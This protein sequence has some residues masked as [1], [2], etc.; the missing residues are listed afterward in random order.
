MSLD[1]YGKG[2]TDYGTAFRTFKSLCYRDIDSR[3]TIIILGD[4]RNNYFANGADVLKDLSRRSRQVIWLNPEPRERW[5]E[6]DAEMKAFLPACNFAEVC[7]SLPDL[8][9]MVSRVLRT[10]H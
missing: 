5:E 2:S 3:S 8:E 4:A 10:A 1:D 6:G 9:R 7:N